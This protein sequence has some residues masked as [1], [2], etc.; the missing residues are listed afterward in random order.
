MLAFSDAITTSWMP[1]AGSPLANF[2][3]ASVAVCS[4]ACAPCDAFGQLRRD[5]RLDRRDAHRPIPS[6]R[7]AML[8]AVVIVVT[9]ASYAREAVI[10]S[11]ISSTG[12]T[13]GY[14]T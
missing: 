3:A 9:P 4:A 11:T 12:L 8:T 10:M 2:S 1:I 7:S 5:D 14:A 13:L 6:A